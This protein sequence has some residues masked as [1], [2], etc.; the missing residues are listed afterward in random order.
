MY[1]GPH[2]QRV[3]DTWALTA[4]LRAQRLRAQGYAVI[5]LDNRG[6]V[7]SRTLLCIIVVLLT[8]TPLSTLCAPSLHRV[9][10]CAHLGLQNAAVPPAADLLSRR[11]SLFLVFTFFANPVILADVALLDC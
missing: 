7:A 9:F 11:A 1:G 6:L 8:L 5:K 10:V 3:A 2:V 4:D